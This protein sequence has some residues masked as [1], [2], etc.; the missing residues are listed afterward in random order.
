MTRNK[1][2]GRSEVAVRRVQH[3]NRDRAG[4]ISAANEALQRQGFVVISSREPLEVGEVI[5]WMHGEEA[6]GI[7]TVVLGCSSVEEVHAQQRLLGYP[8]RPAGK[9]EGRFLYR[10]TAE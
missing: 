3:A 10:V 9:F 5:E 4:S 8:P 6:S 2:Q 1:G 7:K